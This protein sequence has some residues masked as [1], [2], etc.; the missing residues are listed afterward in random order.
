MEKILIK[1]IVVLIIIFLF[2]LMNMVRYYLR[3]LKAEKES[4]KDQERL[5]IKFNR[6]DHLKK[7]REEIRK[8]DENNRKTKI[9]KGI[10]YDRLADGSLIKSYSY[11]SIQT[12]Q[13]YQ[14][15]QPEKN[16]CSG[17]NPPKKP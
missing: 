14:C 7:V 1:I 6:P 3:Q 15:Y 4:K 10:Y 12:Y 5:K 9:V 13:P 8:I 11:E 16:N 17:D 2:I